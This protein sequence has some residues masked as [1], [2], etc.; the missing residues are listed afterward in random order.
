MAR[1]RLS[2]DEAFRSNFEAGGRDVCWPWLGSLRRAKVVGNSPHGG[3]SYGGRVYMA[4]RIAYTLAHGVEVPSS[5]YVCHTCDNAGCVNP[6]HLYL[7]NPTTNMR[8]RAARN[9]QAG[10][11]KLSDDVVREVHRLRLSG[12]THNL[13]SEQLGLNVKSVENF[14]AGRRHKHIYE[15]FHGPKN[16]AP[17]AVGVSRV[18][19]EGFGQA[20]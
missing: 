11:G 1:Q 14:L 10:G 9:R 20:A 13:I 3:F 2:F 12:A 6:S 19:A 8:D 4:H 15:E 16:P 7:G 18:E 5:V 17:A